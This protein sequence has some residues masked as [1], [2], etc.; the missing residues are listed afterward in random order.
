VYTLDLTHSV[1]ACVT[2][3][4]KTLTRPYIIRIYIYG[5]SVNLVLCPPYRA[6]IR[7]IKRQPRGPCV[8]FVA[9]ELYR[10]E[11]TTSYSGLWGQQTKR[12]T[13]STI[14]VGS[15]RVRSQGI[16]NRKLV[17]VCV[18]VL[19]ELIDRFDHARQSCYV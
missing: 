1:Q 17:C 11:L 3:N 18:C 8:T 15:G 13:I 2:K 7:I 4:T 6:D 16:I 19:E 10:V 5:L 9:G 14:V 12:L